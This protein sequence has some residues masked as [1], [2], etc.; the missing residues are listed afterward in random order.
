MAQTIEETIAHLEQQWN[1]GANA[2]HIQGPMRQALEQ[3]LTKV[4]CEQYPEFWALASIA[5]GYVERQAAQFEKALECIG[6]AEEVIHGEL[7][8]QG[9]RYV[10]ARALEE[11]GL[12]YRAQKQYD[13]AVRE[14]DFSHD[15]Y[16]D[17]A[18]A[19]GGHQRFVHDFEGLTIFGRLARVKGIMGNTLLEWGREEDVPKAIELLEEELRYQEE[20]N[21]PLFGLANAHHGLGK[22]YAK[23]QQYKT[24]RRHFYKADEEYRTME[25][26]GER[27]GGLRGR[28]NVALD[29]ADM[30]LAAGSAYHEVRLRLNVALRDIN[31]FSEGDLKMGGADQMRRIAERIDGKDGPLYRR[32]EEALTA[33]EKM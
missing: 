7:L 8:D 31:A 14:L 33:S 29:L 19:T 24:A 10:S 23:A 25:Q 11:K 15:L 30:E 32:V 22:A 2:D 28:V 16:R 4:S 1:L 9:S 6:D 21:A 13:D 12:V 5:L 3:A 17:H 20:T 27:E 18:R 26:K